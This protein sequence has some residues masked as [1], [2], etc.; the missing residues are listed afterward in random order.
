[1]SLGETFAAGFSLS[2]DASI[3]IAKA[4][5]DF[6]DGKR[7]KGPRVEHAYETPGHYSV[8]LTVTDKRDAPS[9]GMFDVVVE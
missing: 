8:T 9:S 4:V 3:C 1:V 6:G 2:Y 5:W 7:A